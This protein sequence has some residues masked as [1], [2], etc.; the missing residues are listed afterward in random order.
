MAKVLTADQ[1]HMTRVKGNGTGFNSVISGHAMGPSLRYACMLSLLAR[2]KK[3]ES[4][5]GWPELLESHQC[6]SGGLRDDRQDSGEELRK[7]V[8]CRRGGARSWACLRRRASAHR[9]SLLHKRNRPQVQIPDRRRYAG[10]KQDQGE[11]EGEGKGKGK[12]K[13]QT[14]GCPSQNASEGHR[15]LPA[16]LRSLADGEFVVVDSRQS[17]PVDHGGQGLERVAIRLH[18]RRTPS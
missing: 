12:G 5:T 14:E 10:E 16:E 15:L 9:R 3:F 8:M 6:E 13:D 4:A 11:G 18:T 2:D 7:E 1:F 17:A